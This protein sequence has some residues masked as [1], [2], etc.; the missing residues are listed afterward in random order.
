MPKGTKPSISTIMTVH[1]GEKYIREA[2]RSILDQN[3]TN[4]DVWV[5]DDGS[6]DRTKE[7]ADGFG[8]PVNYIYQENSGI[9]A[10]WNNGIT[11]SGGEY[12][13]FLDADDTWEPEKIN[14]QISVLQD[15]RQIKA[16]F[17][18]MREFYSPDI[19]EDARRKYKC[20]KE[21]IPGYSAGTILISR[22]DF[23]E[24][25]LFNTK[26]K[27]GIF[28]DWFLR[29]KEMDMKMYMDQQVML[30]RRIHGSNHGIKK[31]DSYVDYVR[32]LKA[33]L[34]RRR[35]NPPN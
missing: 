11:S 34:D 19:N 31:R 13:A 16:A 27:K 6:T 26:W 8:E 33:S 23:M 24:T 2:I 12:L 1:N 28:S 9:A 35:S 22:K 15:N 20:N 17:G 10:G 3:Y 5:V 25:G 32:M 21:A 7:I 30:N 4:L 14:R 29:A 18:Y